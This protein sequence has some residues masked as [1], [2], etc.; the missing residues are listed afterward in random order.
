M[1]IK[2]L[3]N[4]KFKDSM[5]VYSMSGYALYVEGKGFVSLDGEIPY[6]PVGGRKAL[7]SIIEMGGFTE[8][9]AYIMPIN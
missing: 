5:G 1:I 8:E 3:K 9:P 7:Q 2:N 4:F 6:A